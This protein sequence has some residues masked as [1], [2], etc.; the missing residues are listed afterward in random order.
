M[1]TFRTV[2][3]TP[4]G[5][6]RQPAFVGYAEGCEVPTFPVSFEG[7]ALRAVRIASSTELWRT[8]MLLDL[9]VVEVSGLEFGSLRFADNNAW[10]LATERIKADAREHG[11]MRWRSTDPGFTYPPAACEQTK[12][13]RSCPLY[14]CSRC[15]KERPWCFGAYDQDPDWCD[16]CV[17]IYGEP[18]QERAP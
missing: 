13:C 18:S 7:L 11:R 4:I 14:V 15:L 6:R 9:N 5:T 10:V 1:T 16:G 8:A 17:E 3:V 2:E 12:A